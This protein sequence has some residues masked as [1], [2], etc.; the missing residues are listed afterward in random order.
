M[1]AGTSVSTGDGWVQWERGLQTKSL[2]NTATG[3]SKIDP[4]QQQLVASKVCGSELQKTV[5]PQGHLVVTI[6]FCSL[7]CAWRAFSL[8]SWLSGFLILHLNH[9]KLEIRQIAANVSL[10]CQEIQ[11]GRDCPGGGTATTD[12]TPA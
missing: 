9:Q 6:F 4:E 11:Q 1:G 5:P 8:V 3:K 10:V 7:W 2:S 12:T